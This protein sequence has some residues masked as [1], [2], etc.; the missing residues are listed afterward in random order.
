MTEY[1][2]RPLRVFLCHAKEDKAY[3]RKLYQLLNQNGIDSWLDEEKILPGQ[4]W[5]SEISKAINNS[6]IIVVCLSKKSVTKEGFVQKEIKFALD[7]AD[8]KPED[9][10]FIIPARLDECEVPYR[11]VEWQW[12]DLFRRSGISSL[13]ESI[14]SRAEQ[15]G[16]LVP[17]KSTLK[18][19]LPINLPS[20]GVSAVE[21]KP[22][23]DSQVKTRISRKPA[24]N[25]LPDGDEFTWA[26]MVFKKIPA[27]QFIM[28]CNI[29]NVLAADDEGP[30]HN[31]VIP[32]DYWIGRFP[33]TNQHFAEF[34]SWSHYNF[35]WA[36]GWKKKARHPVVAG[37][38]EDVMAYI[39]WLNE[40]EFFSKDLP[41]G[42]C[43]RLPTEAEWEKA[44]RGTD[45]RTWPWGNEF[46]RKCNSSEI[47]IRDTTECGAYSPE[48]DSIYGVG[49]MA[50]NVLEWTQSIYRPYPYLIAQD[51]DD[52]EASGQRVLRGGYY[53][54]NYCDVRTTARF[55]A[56]N[57]PYPVGFR[58][59]V[60]PYNRR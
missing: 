30:I 5:K 26:N 25:P 22:G 21:P 1:K 36:D 56:S 46:G 23:V 50:G 4:S 18:L 60:V 39:K 44:A 42:F 19:F 57:Y 58:L 41:D 8:E 34:V 7:K 15:I 9:T 32:Y 54:S 3:I 6:D 43:F 59:V 16:A 2:N 52:L 35:K 17:D 48:G 33:I 24:K 29:A 38:W 11:L 20:V 49:D 12:V 13:F 53:D 10:I 31:I 51:P 47:Y 14:I 55:L 27:G 45:G 28:G 37:H 40:F